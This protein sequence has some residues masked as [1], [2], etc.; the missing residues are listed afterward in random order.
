ML[1]ID[2]RDF[3]IAAGLIAAAPGPARA[4]A[5]GLQAT[6][7]KTEFID[8]PLGLDTLKPRFSWQLQ[9][10]R[11]GAKQSAYRITAASSETKLKAGV[12]DIW[13]SGRVKSDR[14][15]EVPYEGR[16][17]QSAE[18][19]WWRVQIWDETGRRS[20]HSD[21]SWFEMGLLAPSDWTGDW[22]IAQEPEEAADRA[23]GL[24][25]IWDGKPLDP[26]PRK[27][28][29][30]FSLPADPADAKLL[31]SA[32]DNLVGVWTN[33]R[34]AQ[35]PGQVFWGTMQTI[36]V[37]LVGGDNVI[38]VEATALTDGFL[39]PD[40]GAV[41]ALLRVTSRDGHVTRFT[42]GPDWR[43]SNLDASDW[44]TTSF[45]D[46]AWQHSQSSHAHA[47]C[48]PWPAADAM[49]FRRSFSVAKPIARARLYATALGAYEAY[50]NGRRVGDAR[51]APEIAVASDHVFYQ[52]YDVTDFLQ[53]SENV[54]GLLIGDGWYASAFA[55]RNERFSLGNGPR[56]FLT[57]LVLDYQDGSQDIVTTDGNWRTT[58]SAIRTSEI[59]NGET[60]DARLEQS[61]WNRADFDDSHWRP[62]DTGEKPLVRLI[63]QVSPP[64]REMQALSAKSVTEPRPGTF[65]LD[66]GQNFAGWCRLRAKGT[67]GTAITLRHAEILKPSGEIDT[68]NLRGA[69]ATDT[70][71][72]RGDPAGEAYEPHFTYHG[73]RYVEVT[74]YP[75]RPDAKSLD[76]VVVHTDAPATGTF[77]VENA[78]V[79]HIWHNALWSQR[80]NFFGVPTDCPQRDERM[81]WM[82]DIQVFLDAAAFNMDV[83]AFIRRFLAEVRAGQTPDGAF[84][85]VTPQPRSFP[86]ML[87]AGWSEA[88]VILP[89]T[90]YRRYGD[91]R[92]IEDN[93]AAM[94]AW[95]AFVSDANPDFLWRNK[96][97]LD[98]GDWLSVDA[99][100][101]WDET[102][103][104]M[105]VA[106]AYWAYVAS[107]MAEMAKAIGLVGDAT[108][109][110]EMRG[111]IGQAFAS[112]FVRPDGTIGNGS[113]TSYVLALRF[114]LVPEHLR[115]AAGDHLAAG[116]RA[117]G[118]KLSTGFLGTPYLL[119]ALSD[120]GHADVAVSLLLQ[121]EYPS[122]G[123]MIRKGA[124]TM[125]ERW[126]G[127]VGDVSMNSYNH[128]AFGAVVGFLYRRLAGISPAA[129][130]FRRIDVNPIFDTRVGRVHAEYQSCLGRITTDVSGDAAG[131]SRLR[132]SVPAN[133]I[134]RIQLPARSTVWHESGRLLDRRPD[135]KV[136]DRNTSLL[137]V[138]VGS[139]DY[140][141]GA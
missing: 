63:P 111:K 48:E 83:D 135:L 25:W 82:G 79:Q 73:F 115:A 137:T 54:I 11:R 109:Y 42:S 114:G 140:D 118:T 27:F 16:P 86:P 10:G 72:L 121:T 23:A 78:L 24:H 70:Y 57:R 55:W 139:G 123:Y 110:T 136:L 38:C 64:I 20:A 81:G 1:K 46:S 39:P 132:L 5:N 66:F 34:P 7:L 37:S 15:F 45:D 133:A 19:A 105:L 58:P 104:R 95:I 67:T 106:T 68:S 35:L 99:K 113:Q 100:Q 102:T 85:V 28:R 117:R 13:D 3:M 138:E 116:I 53:S 50:L 31:L 43:V 17:L 44:T 112:T 107:L 6:A 120:T 134:A 30:R 90:L 127:D 4:R 71:V 131:L 74:G 60:Y 80:S 77:T 75:G 36:P 56:R 130:G 128:Y 89:W 76:G 122:W 62:V 22:L 126:N 108:R 65:V 94:S 32:K 14:C 52:T 59:Y 33:G 18:R 92:V 98:L 97:G 29:F 41:A 103:P 87:T 124:T 61:T 9:S 8:R 93:W 88:G 119:D 129:P 125:W 141:F 2:R 12:A 69:K 49:L 96:R 51:L 21:A 91:M 47:W 40:G 26:R 84:P 101:P